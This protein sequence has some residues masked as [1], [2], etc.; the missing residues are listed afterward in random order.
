MLMNLVIGL[1]QVYNRMKWE[2]QAKISAIHN[3]CDV[4]FIYDIFRISTL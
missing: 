4:K 1:I 3:A 2:V